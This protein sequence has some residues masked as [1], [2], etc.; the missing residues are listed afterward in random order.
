MRIIILLSC[1]VLTGCQGLQLQEVRSK[2]KFG[3]EWRSKGASSNRVHDTRWYAQTGVE[4]KW[5][6]GVNT[7]VT[8]R[9]RDVDGG[10]GGHDNGVWFEVSLPIWKRDKPDFAKQIKL[11]EERLAQLER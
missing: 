1:I 11:L 8:Y 10:N 6:N 9:R 7:T 4:F 2:N 3:P 5:N